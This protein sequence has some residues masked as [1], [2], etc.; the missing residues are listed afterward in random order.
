MTVNLSSKWLIYIGKT[1]VS[2]SSVKPRESNTDYRNPAIDNEILQASVS[3][4]NFD[5]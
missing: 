3:N 2:I 4:N 5:F 1:A